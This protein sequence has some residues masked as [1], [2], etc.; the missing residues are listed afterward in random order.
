LALELREIQIPGVHIETV[1][2]KKRALALRLVQEAFDLDHNGILDEA[3]RAATRLILY[4]QSFGGAATVKFSRQ[5]R[6]LGIPVVLTIQIDSVGV[7]DEVIPSNVRRAANLYQN[8][9]ILI[10]G[11]ARIR[12]EDP[13][14]TEVIGNFEYDY[15][16]KEID[17]SF[18]PWHKKI[19]RISHTKMNYDQEVWDRVKELVLSEIQRV[20]Q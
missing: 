2:N 11:E 5:M 6:D 7:G 4:G 14:R 9:G 12:A 20:S 10:Q 18:V 1:E 3:E 13:S 16:N 8:N 15:T 19:F 17:I